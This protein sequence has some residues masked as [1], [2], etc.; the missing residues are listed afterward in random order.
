M[1]NEEGHKQARE[2]RAD[3]DESRDYPL[4]GAIGEIA[5]LVKLKRIFFFLN[6][7]TNSSTG[8]P[9]ALANRRSIDRRGSSVFMNCHADFRALSSG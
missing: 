1:S 6:H 9:T 8:T 2:N 4:A 3:D 5:C 7:L